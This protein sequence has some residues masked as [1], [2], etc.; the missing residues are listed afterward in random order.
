MQAGAKP[1]EIDG[2]APVAVGEEAIKLGAHEE[3]VHCEGLLLH[4]AIELDD[5]TTLETTDAVLEL[6]GISGIGLVV[7]ATENDVIWLLVLSNVCVVM[8]AQPVVQEVVA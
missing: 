2:T 3:P 1:G 8:M 7:S 6:V 5:Q 4:G